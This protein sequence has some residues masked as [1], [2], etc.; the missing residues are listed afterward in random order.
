MTL[1]LSILIPEDVRMLSIDGRVIRVL[2]K[3]QKELRFEYENEQKLEEALRDWAKSG[4]VGKLP[5]QAMEQFQ[6]R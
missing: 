6:T 1:S 4:A 5:K 2:L 3:G